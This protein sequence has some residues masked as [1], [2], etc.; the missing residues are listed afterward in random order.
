MSDRPY[1]G[2]PVGATVVESRLRLCWLDRISVRICQ[3]W[4]VDR[5]RFGRGTRPAAH[6]G[7]RILTLS[8]QRRQSG[9]MDAA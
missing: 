3:A 1:S 2:A 6:V 9:A 7:R 5:R 8:K 4:G